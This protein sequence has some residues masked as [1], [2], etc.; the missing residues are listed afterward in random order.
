MFWENVNISFHRLRE[1]KEKNSV[2]RCGDGIMKI[3]IIKFSEGG[4]KGC[5]YMKILLE[6][7]PL[8]RE[9]PLVVHLLNDWLKDIGTDL[10]ESSRVDNWIVF[11]LLNVCYYVLSVCLQD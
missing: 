10:T 2:L 11:V 8:G 1:T 5:V 3:K 9:R 7:K 4:E 6:K